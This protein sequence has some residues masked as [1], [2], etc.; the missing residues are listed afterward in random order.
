MTD[1]PNF[2]FVPGE[3]KTE[4]EDWRGVVLAKMPN[5]NLVGYITDRGGA[6]DI[7]CWYK[8][9]CDL[10]VKGFADLIPP[11]PE[12]EWIACWKSRSAGYLSLDFHAPH[13]TPD[14]VDRYA[15][16]THP[17]FDD[18]CYIGP[19]RVLKKQ[20]PEP[21]DEGQEVWVN[22]Y[23]DDEISQQLWPSKDDAVR[24][25][26]TQATCVGRNRIRLRREF[27]K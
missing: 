27:D 5:G 6:C 2:E 17:D 4:D 11:E 19:V 23:D 20:P 21:A 15:G 13:P 14:D 22:V 10:T 12:Y 16:S 26:N 9:G 1:K 3:Y 24:H 18:W 7:R 8:D 25:T